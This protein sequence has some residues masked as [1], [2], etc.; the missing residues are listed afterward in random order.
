MTPEPRQIE[1][2]IFEDEVCRL[3][4]ILYA[5]NETAGAVI[6]D[7]LERDGIFVTDTVVVVIEATRSTRMDKAAKDAAK[8]QQAVTKLAK[9]HRDKAIRGFL[10]TEKEPT[11]DQRKVVDKTGPNVGIMSFATFQARL[12]DARQYVSDR[13]R[14]VF[15]SALDPLTQS[16]NVEGP[17]VRLD[18]LEVPARE[19]THSIEGILAT[20]R[21]GRRIVLRGEYGVGKS[22][23]L[24]EVFRTAASDLL[25][26]ST[27]GFVLHLNLRDHQGQSD[28][29]EAIERHA[30]LVG[31]EPRQLVRAWRTGRTPVLLDGFDEI[32]TA[33]WPGRV[34]SLKDIRRRSVALV[35]HFVEETP[36]TAGVLIAGRDHFFDDDGEMRAAFNLPA[37]VLL[38]AASDFTEAQI[39]D[40]LKS[41]NWTEFIPEWLPPR[42]LLIGHLAARELLAP[43]LDASESVD[44]AEGWNLLVDAL[45]AREARVDVGVDGGAV[46]RILERLATRARATPSG[47]GPMSFDD[48]VVAFNSVSGYLPD[49]EAYILLLR[50][51]G[52][53]VFAAA[54]NSRMF[55]DEDLTDVLRAG[56]VLEFVVSPFAKDSDHLRGWT[57]LLGPLGM[58]VTV[59]RLQELAIH[60]SA[61]LSA[62]HEAVIRGEQFDGLKID[63]LRVL[64]QLG[65]S[66]SSGLTL[67]SH[68][69]PSLEFA[70]GAVANT[71]RF[72]DCM[73]ETLDVTDLAD[74]G[75]LPEFHGCVISRVD[76]ASGVDQLASARFDNC[77]FGSFS[78]SAENMSAILTLPLTDYKKVML[79]VLRKLYA[80]AGR[81]RKE[82]AFF[83]GGLTQS[84]RDQVPRVLERLQS[85]HIAWSS[86]NKGTI[87]WSANR[88][89]TRR[90]MQ[91]LATPTKSDDPLMSDV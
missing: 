27:Q 66:W 52:L 45:T 18:L 89:M 28:P 88:V 64:M 31:F 35:R 56:D 48:T 25:R 8:L 68:V 73:I 83:R 53:Q 82:N 6:L 36:S 69:V 7:G 15:G 4:R 54:E 74:A 61:L 21:T 37:D 1:D 86:R 39:S 67:R 57:T 43:L 76:G 23:T 85:E 16:P 41:R 46:R 91:I 60:E 5:G 26:D 42:P 79:S 59:H 40:Y 55:I 14:Y 33:N 51:P 38:L 90:V 11:P 24:R 10:V 72:E 49:P 71:V 65:G 70:A 77:E 50:L 84:Q 63:L 29:V 47:L 44:A 9:Q 32:S 3:A 75:A 58:S 19:K 13:Q 20:L 80:Q 12:V 22:M 34:G 2:K 81:G 17:Y 62:L 87:L 30:R 78:E